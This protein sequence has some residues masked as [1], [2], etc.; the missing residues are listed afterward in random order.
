MAKVYL[1]STDTL[2]IVNNSNT[3]VYGSDGKQIVAVASD[4]TNITVDQNIA[5]VEFLGATN[6]YKYAQIGNQMAVYN[7]DGA[8][9]AAIPLQGDSDGTQFQ[10]SN[11]TTNAVLTNG[12][13]TLGGGSVPSTPASVTMTDSAITQT[14]TAPSTPTPTPDSGG[15]S[16]TDGGGSSGG[17]SGGGETMADKTAPTVSW[18]VSDG[19]KISVTSNEDGTVAIRSSTTLFNATL[20][21]NQPSE[22]VLIDKYL[23]NNSAITAT[24]S[25]YDK[26]GNETK[27]TAN[28]LFGS[29]DDDSS[30]ASLSTSDVMFGFDGADNFVLKNDV[31]TDKF[32]Y[33]GDYR[34]TF[35]DTVTFF[36]GDNAPTATVWTTVVNGWTITNGVATKS[37]AA[38]GDFIKDFTAAIAANSADGGAS[39]DKGVGEVVSFYD[40]VSNS[41][42]LFGEGA[43]AANNA[44][45]RIAGD[46]GNPLTV[47]PDKMAPSVY[48]RSVKFYENTKTLVISGDNMDTLLASDEAIGSD[49]VKRLDWMFGFN[50]NVDSDTDVTNDIWLDQ[51]SVKSACVT[52]SNTLTIEL[53]QLSFTEILKNAGYA[54][55]TTT[56]GLP[57]VDKIELN[58][59]FVDQVKN[60]QNYSSNISI[61]PVYVQTI[62]ASD[63]ISG[64]FSA[65]G[66][67]SEL[68]LVFDGVDTDSYTVDCA[69]FNGYTISLD[70]SVGQSY[71]FTNMPEFLNNFNTDSDV[72]VK[73]ASSN[74]MN[75]NLFG[76]G[77][78]ELT[79]ERV[80]V[81]FDTGS[82]NDTLKGI[83]TFVF[84]Y[85]DLDANDK[86]ESGN[87][88]YPNSYSALHLKAVN[89]MATIADEQFTNITKI[90][91]LQIDNGSDTNITLGAKANTAFDSGIKIEFVDVMAYG[92]NGIALGLKSSANNKLTLDASSYTKNVALTSEK[93]SNIIAGGSGNDTFKL[94]KTDS[95]VIFGVDKATNGVDNIYSDITSSISNLTFDFKAFLGSTGSKNTTAAY[96][97]DGLDLTTYNVGVVYNKQNALSAS[98]IS[99]SLASNKI[100]LADNAKAVVFVNGIVGGIINNTTPVTNFDIYYI[101][102]TNV[103]TDAQA[104]DV[105]LVGQAHI[106]AD[107][108]GMS[109]RDFASYIA[110]A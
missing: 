37:G 16:S 79:S 41:T 28:I 49:V 51:S 57:F 88:S 85:T 100:A 25:V 56:V 42:Y 4:V 70:G 36:S 17:S 29:K 83:G 53:A 13:M 82:G 107:I 39:Y 22:L 87:T 80:G 89:D 62:K 68:K 102:D 38:S 40:S 81:V 18:T 73:I 78:D 92:S 7:K 45:C 52:D 105:E 3:V 93:G 90:Y 2:F 64:A 31:I 96:F 20:I 103:A 86:I 98:D 54:G 46:V 59:F 12:A 30:I 75:F 15:G 8:L 44:S 5:K 27:D 65:A 48:V 32:Q 14:T 74:I 47:V 97:Y 95:T 109:P 76:S 94:G 61:L 104:W 35:G 6:D 77:N 106:N 71:E 19:N 55:D 23:F 50:W 1:E 72:N 58:N 26:A 108:G 33:I 69:D 34:A 99:T 101:K 60:V 21:A 66:S 11:G 10:F 91:E 24:L 63:S 67:K 110:I 43:S 84:K 9:I